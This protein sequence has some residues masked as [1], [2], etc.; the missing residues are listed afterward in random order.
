[1]EIRLQREMDKL[2]LEQN[3]NVHTKWIEIERQLN[4]NTTPIQGVDVTY[5]INL[6]G[7]GSATYL[8]ALK[9]QHALVSEQETTSAD[10]VLTM[11]V[12]DF[13]KLL[14]GKLNT[15]AAYM[16]GKL[17]VKGSLGLALKLESILR[18]YQF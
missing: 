6:T 18:Q 15:T 13:Y 10:C 11:S 1:M 7:E 9:D 14:I 3:L 2:T 5:G 16:T 8:L 4:E 12:D 17:K